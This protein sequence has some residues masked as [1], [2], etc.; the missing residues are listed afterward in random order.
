MYHIYT[1]KKVIERKTQKPLTNI[2]ILY[3]KKEDTQMNQSI[4]DV[5]TGYEELKTKSD[6]IY[7]AF[8]N[9][10]TTNLDKMLSEI[11]EITEKKYPEL[12]NRYKELTERTVCDSV[13]VA[14][15]GML[16]F[17]LY[18]T[19]EYAKTLVTPTPKVNPVKF[20]LFYRTELP[21]LCNKLLNGVFSS[22]QEFVENART[23]Y[24]II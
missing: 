2:Y 1:Y 11:K 8:M 5:A 9:R 17:G 4:Y 3:I 24:I 21:V 15:H 16:L 7:D 23:I 20:E 13:R 10:D 19:P 22:L 12:S 18:M 14:K 6:V